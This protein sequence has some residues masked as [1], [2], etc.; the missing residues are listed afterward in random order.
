MPSWF[1]KK[2]SVAAQGARSGG[3]EKFET[4]R[5]QGPASAETEKDAP[6]SKN[7]NGVMTPEAAE[8]LDEKMTGGSPF[9]NAKLRHMDVYLAQS[10]SVAQWRLSSFISLVLLAMSV[11]G[12]I[13]L[14]G[15]VKIQPFVV[16]VDEHGYAVP[17]QMAEVSGVNER[18]IASQI[19]QFITNSRIRVTDRD[20][21]I[22]FAKNSYKS[23]GSNSAALR[24]LNNYFSSAPPTRDKYPVKIDIRSIIPLTPRT[25]QAEW[26]E[27]TT[28]ANGHDIEVNYQGVY[29]VAVSP[30]ANMQNLVS[31]PLGVYI[32]DYHVQEKIK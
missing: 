6:S 22:I 29:E 14:S 19:G 5:G 3:T 23:I 27:A 1:G 9:L 26:S 18:V 31:N 12:N 2:N 17:I 20:A 15:S 10:Q 30:P 24:V 7:K 25:Y 16:Q 21:Q 11:A 4:A 32:T 28:N 13:Y 8:R